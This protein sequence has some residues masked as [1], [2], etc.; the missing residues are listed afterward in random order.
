MKSDI[1]RLDHIRL[2]IREFGHREN[3]F[4]TINYVV[5]VLTSFQAH[6]NINYVLRGS[7][8]GKRF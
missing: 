8:K 4:R 3:Y 1:A 5:N 2:P 6:D 7:I